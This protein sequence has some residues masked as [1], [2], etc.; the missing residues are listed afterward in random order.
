MLP[1]G[2]QQMRQLNH[3]LVWPPIPRVCSLWKF[4]AVLE[5]FGL[6]LTEYSFYCIFLI[7]PFVGQF[8]VAGSAAS[9]GS[10]SGLYLSSNYG[11][12]WTLANFSAGMGWTSVCSDSTGNRLAA[13]SVN[14]NTGSH[15]SIICFQN[16]IFSI[17]FFHLFFLRL[18][19]GIY[20]SSNRG[21]DWLKSDA[22]ALA[23]TGIASDSTGQ[24]LVACDN[25]ESNNGQGHIYTSTDYGAQF[26]Q[27]PLSGNNYMSVA[28]D[29]TGQK[30]AAATTTFIYTSID[31]GLQWTQTSAPQHTYNKVVSSSS[32]HF[33]IA[34]GVEVLYTSNN[35]GASWL[36]S[37]LPP[38]GIYAAISADSAGR[39]LVAGSNTLYASSDYGLSWVAQYTLTTGDWTAACSDSAG[40]RLVSASS[41]QGL[42]NYPSNTAWPTAAPTTATPTVVPTSH[43]PSRYVLLIR[44]CYTSKIC[45]SSNNCIGRSPTVQPSA[46][47]APSAT[48]APSVILTAMPTPT[49]TNSWVQSSAPVSQYISWS[50]VASNAEG[51]R[52]IAV[53]V[54]E[55]N[56][57]TYTFLYVSADF[58]ETW[59][60]TGPSSGYWVSVGSDASGLKLAAAQQDGYI[61]TSPN[62][63]VSWIQ[64]ATVQSWICISSDASGSHL[65]AGVAYG[66]SFV[67]SDGGAHWNELSSGP[68]SANAI[69]ASS[70][71]QYVVAS[72][73]SPLGGYL[74]LSNNYGLNWTYWD[75]NSIWAGVASDATGNYLIAVSNEGQVFVNENRTAEWRPS[76]APLMPYLNGVASDSTGRYVVLA[77]DDIYTSSDY[78][79]SF[80]PSSAAGQ[81]WA[82]V[83]SDSTGQ[84]LVA[85]ES[86]PG[87]GIWTCQGAPLPPV[88]SWYPTQHP[89]FQPTTDVLYVVSFRSNIT[90]IGLT[91]PTLDSVSQATIASATAVSMNL[92]ASAVTF[93]GSAT[94]FIDVSTTATAVAA[95]AQHQSG[96]KGSLRTAGAKMQDSTY[97][98]IAITLTSVVLS[99]TSYYNTTQ[100]YDALTASLQSAVQSGSYDTA[101]HNS[102]TSSGATALK[103]AVA[104][105]VHSSSPTVTTKHNGGGGSSG[106]G[107][108]GGAIAG[109]VVG[110]VPVLALAAAVFWCY[111]K[112]SPTAAAPSSARAPPDAAGV[113]GA[114]E[115]TRPVGEF[116]LNPVHANAAPVA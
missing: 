63:G 99:D 44:Y 27:S 26:S 60:K 97:S 76:G 70:S 104:V 57:Y 3:G 31:R 67:S 85:A 11:F 33:L 71:G 87:G 68:Y 115:G 81:G 62:G 14:G 96:N 89:T 32:G 28:S 19:E 15:V 73:S 38:S 86:Y 51:D 92:P 43:A 108:S 5:Y 17:Y 45:L 100:L 103:N 35:S 74:Y 102:A 107:L 46:T 55:D 1:F 34:G 111:R 16:I 105:S 61:Y 22:S 4:V 112:G 24:Y 29:S 77:G 84:F 113:E 79:A 88:P 36:R 56:Q 12:S 64:R 83:A 109:I 58:G 23:Y 91:A 65:F 52:L 42:F 20:Y 95:F 98:L 37:E 90:L 50:A 93:V 39:N 75:Y 66:Y 30:L 94:A 101:L 54:F 110:S 80:V 2:L 47:R 18:A 10:P 116:E 13:T 6:V 69:A 53:Q 49:L 25:T 72:D 8:V 114:F 106:T 41:D 7:N 82:A 21:I 59:S 40:Q 78:G 48:L 9:S